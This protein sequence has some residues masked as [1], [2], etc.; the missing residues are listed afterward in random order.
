MYDD[1]NSIE[2]H[3]WIPKKAFL[4]IPNGDSKKREHDD[5]KMIIEKNQLKRL[6]YEGGLDYLEEEDQRLAE[7]KKHL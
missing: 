7:F 4:Y 5:F 3:Q 1:Y 6:I 2:N